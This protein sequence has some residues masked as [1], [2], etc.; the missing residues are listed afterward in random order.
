MKFWRIVLFL[1]IGYLFSCNGNS[2]QNFEDCSQGKPTAIFSDSLEQIVKHKFGID[3][4]VGVEFIQFNNGIYLEI[5]Q[6]GCH[7]VHQEFRFRLPGKSPKNS[8]AFWVDQSISMLRFLGNQSSLHLAFTEWA[9]AIDKIAKEVNVGQEINLSNNIYVKI[10]KI[11]SSDHSVL[12][13]ELFQKD[14]YK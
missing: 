14:K 2:N 3:K 1:S 13:V 11:P 4:N 9:N 8:N 5:Y 10:D 6:S 12:I 7:L